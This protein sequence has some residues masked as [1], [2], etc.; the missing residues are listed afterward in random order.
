MQPVYIF[1]TDMGNDVDD[2]LAQILLIRG[3]AQGHGRWGAAV[4]NKGNRLA[5]AFVDLINRYYDCPGIPIG[6]CSHGPTPEEGSVGENAFLRPVLEQL[7]PD[8]LDY[9]PDAREWPDAVSVLRKTLAQAEDQSVIYISIGFTTI[10]ADL[11]RSPADQYSPLSGLE[12]VASKMKFV[13]MMGGEFGHLEHGGDPHPEHNIVGDV[14]SAQSVMNMLP[15]PIFFSGFEVGQQFEF[16]GFRIRET[17]AK[18]PTHPLSHTYDLYQGFAHNRPLW[19][20]TAVLFAL[21]PEAE[22]FDLSEPGRVVVSADGL[23]HFKP[24]EGGKHH[25]LK[26][27]AEMHF[28]IM[29][30]FVGYCLNP[31]PLKLFRQHPPELCLS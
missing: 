26:F 2:L 18:D 23:T 15:V 28:E 11:L 19:D 12:L 4:I 5:P 13:S 27:R 30:I 31:K 16:P 6:W 10:I 3:L 22:Y 24:V 29:L 21:A 14:E 1:D 20:L 8:Y 17:F 9:D 25:Y 7:G